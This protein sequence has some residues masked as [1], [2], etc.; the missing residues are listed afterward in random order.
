MVRF[1]KVFCLFE[2]LILNI[3]VIFEFLMHLWYL[4]VKAELFRNFAEKFNIF[5]T[6]D[7]YSFKRGFDVVMEKF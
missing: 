5:L 6:W 2:S 7:K 4:K 1:N 3:C